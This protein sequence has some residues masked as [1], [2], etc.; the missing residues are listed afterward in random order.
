MRRLLF[1][2][3]LCTLLGGCVCTKP[4]PNANQLT[5][6]EAAEGWSLLFDGKTTHGWT[7]TGDVSVHDGLLM[8]GGTRSSVAMTT[9]TYRDFDLRFLYRG[10]PGSSCSCLLAEDI[11]N[12][13]V[14]DG[15]QFEW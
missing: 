4:P 10:A 8:I 7:T 2:L 15:I 11:G 6:Q 14:S 3:V 13:M 9:G 1:T 5:P 12:G